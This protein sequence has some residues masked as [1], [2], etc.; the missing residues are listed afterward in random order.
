M[1]LRVALGWG[2]T[3]SREQ[4]GI[5]QVNR[6]VIAVP[7]GVVIDDLQVFPHWA[8]IEVFL[9]GDRG[10]DLVDTQ[11]LDL[12]AEQR[13]EREDP[14]PPILRRRGQSPRRGEPRRRRLGVGSGIRLLGRRG[15]HR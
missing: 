14:K 12:V 8:D 4:V 3:I 1:K 7:G 13:V 2:E 10:G 9:P 11:S 15:A 6:G 5:V